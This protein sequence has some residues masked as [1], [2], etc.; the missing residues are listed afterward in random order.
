M[1]TMLILT[2]CQITIVAT[3]P[4]QTPIIIT[5]PTTTPTITIRRTIIK[6]NR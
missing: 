3:M 2:G 5:P 1:T 6:P 4:P